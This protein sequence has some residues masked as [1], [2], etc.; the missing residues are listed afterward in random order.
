MTEHEQSQ[1]PWSD[2]R[3]H[4]YASSSASS[5]WEHK[6]LVDAMKKVRDAWQAD[7]DALV[8]QLD[9]ARNWA[10]AAMDVLALGVEL[11]PLDQLGKWKSVGAVQHLFDLMVLGKDGAHES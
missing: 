3:I 10:A 8:A 1:Q 9:E 5:A 4:W 11:M 6:H 7:R 2:E